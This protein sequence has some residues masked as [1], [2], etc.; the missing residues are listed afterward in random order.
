[1]DPVDVLIITAL[2]EEYDA[3]L[4]VDVGAVDEWAVV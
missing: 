2:P 3:A 1:M 4:M